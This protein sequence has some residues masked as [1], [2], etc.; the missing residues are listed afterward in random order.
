MNDIEALRRRYKPDPIRVLFIGES[1]PDSGK[2]FYEGTTQLARHMAK[3]FGA[4]SDFPEWF[5]QRGCYLDD[6]VLDPINK[7]SPVE[8]RQAHKDAVPGLAERVRTYSPL[9]VITLLVTIG[10]SVS[11]ALRR[12]GYTGEHHVVAFPGNGQQGRFMKEMA[13][14][15][16]TLPLAPSIC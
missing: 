7:V 6:L 13:Q 11:E 1:P 10:P 16:P 12:A 2:F 8:R 14:I 15:I 4:P 9:C 3:C 5:M